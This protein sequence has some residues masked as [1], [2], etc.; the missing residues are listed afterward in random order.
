MLE[1]KLSHQRP[2]LGLS[3][4][5]LCLASEFFNIPVLSCMLQQFLS[6]TLAKRILKDIFQINGINYANTEF[7]DSMVH[8]LGVE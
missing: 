2:V 8:I 4:C 6:L 1:L 7:K 3:S 5:E